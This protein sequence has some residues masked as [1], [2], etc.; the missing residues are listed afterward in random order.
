MQ[1]L[2]RGWGGW[3]LSNTSHLHVSVVYCCS[4]GF[5]SGNHSILV[6]LELFLSSFDM[7]LSL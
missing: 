6:Y 2:G 1:Q 7:A 5:I 3:G 4:A